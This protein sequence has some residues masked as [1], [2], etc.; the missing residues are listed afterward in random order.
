MEVVEVSNHMHLSD[1]EL[2][3]CRAE[4]HNNKSS[5]SVLLQSNAEFCTLTMMQMLSRQ[6]YIVLY[7]VEHLH[8]ITT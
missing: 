2:A 7:V 1:G 4:V 8:S 6:E 3:E 5:C